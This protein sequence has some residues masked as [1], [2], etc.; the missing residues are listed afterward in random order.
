MDFF[1]AP[2]NREEQMN[3]II[4]DTDEIIK[5]FK[6]ISE[7]MVERFDY[8]E[9]SMTNLGRK[10]INYREE[11]KDPGSNLGNDQVNFI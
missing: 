5:S 7:M 4:E 8:S 9:E 1:N 10:L 6:E 2:I 11:H 3:K